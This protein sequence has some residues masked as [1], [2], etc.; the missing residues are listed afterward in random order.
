M[1]GTKKVIWIINQYAG[2][3][4]HGM[5]FRTYYLAKNF[6]KKHEVNV[7]SASFSHV[8]SSPPDVNSNTTNLKV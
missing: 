3:P 7:F 5:T 6:I 8:M 1:A 2:S 4:Y